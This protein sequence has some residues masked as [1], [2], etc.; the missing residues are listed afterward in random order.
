MR[1]L[2]VGDMHADVQVLHEVDSAAKSIMAD[3]VILLGDY[4]DPI[5]PPFWIL[6]TIFAP[7]IR[8]CRGAKAW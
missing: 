8:F 4:L 6:Q 7:S 2:I 1:T 5:W 3:R